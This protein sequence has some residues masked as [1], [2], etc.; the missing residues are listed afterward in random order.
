MLLNALQDYRKPVR[1]FTKAGVQGA[2]GALRTVADGAAPGF[3]APGL[4]RYKDR[5]VC[6]PVQSTLAWERPPAPAVSALVPEGVS[7][8]APLETPRSTGTPS[9]GTC[10]SAR[11]PAPRGGI[12][13]RSPC[14]LRGLSIEEAQNRVNT[15][16]RVRSAVVNAAWQAAFELP[17]SGPLPSVLEEDEEEVRAGPFAFPMPT[18]APRPLPTPAADRA[19]LDRRQEQCARAERAPRARPGPVVQPL[20][21]DTQLVPLEELAQTAPRWRWRGGSSPGSLWAPPLKEPR[22]QAKAAPDEESVTT[23]APSAGCTEQDAETADSLV[24]RSPDRPAPW[25]WPQQI[26]LDGSSTGSSSS[27]SSYTSY[28]GRSWGRG[29]SPPIGYSIGDRLF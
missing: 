28:G 4:V 11:S 17:R 10:P 7:V 14:P 16:R 26:P 24:S 22:A 3:R 29:R 25:Q 15:G 18:P 13:P 12:T 9:V 20:A 23:V 1:N 6:V 27:R 8:D 5:T 2:D 21:T 19:I